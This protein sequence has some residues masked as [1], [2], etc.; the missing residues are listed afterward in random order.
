MKRGIV[1]GLF[2]ALIS[3][4][5]WTPFVSSRLS[6]TVPYPDGYREWTHV[7]SSLVSPAHGTYA[8]GGGFHHIYANDKAIAGY[9]TRTFPEGSIIVFD[10]LEMRDNAGVFEEGARRQT[11]VMHKDSVRFAATGGWGFQRF[12]KDSKTELAA[13]PAPNQ[14]YACHQKLKPGDLVIS[15]YRP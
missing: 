5:A 3:A 10:W 9:R 11:D 12:V 13:T 14:C 6:D 8:T 2:T 15:T 1:V 4:I 7:K